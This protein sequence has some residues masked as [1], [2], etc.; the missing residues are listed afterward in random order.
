M[1][2]ILWNDHFL[3][4]F[5]NANPMPTTALTPNARAPAI[6]IPLWASEIKTKTIT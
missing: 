6:A 2:I 3:K 1:M 4:F 5:A